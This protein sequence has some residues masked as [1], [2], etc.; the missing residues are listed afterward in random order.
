MGGASHTMSRVHEFR[1]SDVNVGGSHPSHGR[2]YIN[3]GGGGSCSSDVMSTQHSGT[4]AAA[5]LEEVEEE[6]VEEEEVCLGSI[7]TSSPPTSR[8]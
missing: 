8:G 4:P 6:E 1:P 7:P 2:H 3:G 5:V